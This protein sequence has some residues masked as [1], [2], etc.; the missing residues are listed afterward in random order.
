MSGKRKVNGLAKGII[1][2]EEEGEEEEY[3]YYARNKS[4]QV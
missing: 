1:D 3:Y 4:I 2:W